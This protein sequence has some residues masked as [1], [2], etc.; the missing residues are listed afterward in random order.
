VVLRGQN[1]RNPPNV[2]VEDT[3]LTAER[4]VNEISFGT[5]KSAEVDLPETC[6]VKDALILKLEELDNKIYHLIRSN[7]CFKEEIDSLR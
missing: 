7:Q 3:Y 5:G 6:D 1:A 4:R 2:N